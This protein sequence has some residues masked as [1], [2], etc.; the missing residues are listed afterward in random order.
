MIEK[1]APANTPEKGPTPMS[2]SSVSSATN[3]YQTSYNNGFAQSIQDFNALK[4]ALQSGNLSNAQSAFATWQQDIQN[5]PRM[6]SLLNGSQS[7]SSQISQDYQSLQS[8]LQSGDVASAQKAFAS[9][10]QD[11]QTQMQSGQ[12]KGHHHH[13]HH[14]HGGQS[15]TSTAA[16][17]A[18]STNTNSGTSAINLLA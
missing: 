11:L 13:H 17:N 12:V 8:A 1:I 15:S 14:H 18:T 2:V 9:F 10:Q 6:Q 7:G 5:D 16:T 4:N 3:L